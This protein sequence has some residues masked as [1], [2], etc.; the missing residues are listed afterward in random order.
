MT[1][2]KANNRSLRVRHFAAMALVALAACSSGGNKPKVSV[3]SGNPTTTT[4]AASTAAPKG[5]AAANALTYVKGV[6][7]SKPSDVQTAIAVAAPGS[8]AHAYATFEFNQAT[9][10]TQAGRPTSSITTKVQSDG[11]IQACAGLGAQQQCLTYSD[12][13]ADAN[14]LVTT[15]SVN[16]Q[17]MDGRAIEPTNLSVQAAGGT[18][19]VVSAIEGNTADTLLIAFQAQAGT[20]QLSIQAYTSTYVNPGGAQL[21]ADASSSVVPSNDIQPSATVTGVVAFNTGKIGGTWT[22]TVCPPNYQCADAKLT[23]A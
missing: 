21:Q 14:G 20:E 1:G 10:N 22:M 8:P 11:S 17:T 5:T 2:P 19:T 7:A 9:A 6:T 3:G 4:T 16:G 12:F 13:K 23:V 18:V 15:M